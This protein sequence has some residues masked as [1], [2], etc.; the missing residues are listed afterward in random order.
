MERNKILMKMYHLEIIAI[1]EPFVDS[2]IVMSF[3]N[4]LAT[5]NE[6]ANNNGKIWLF[7]NGD[8]DCVIKYQDE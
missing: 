8:V 4:Q 2:I 3:N 5:D 1:L 7:F 6:I